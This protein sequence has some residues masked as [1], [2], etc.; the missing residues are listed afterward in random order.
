[1]PS[2]IREI[3]SDSVINRIQ[4]MRKVLC[5][6]PKGSSFELPPNDDVSLLPKSFLLTFRKLTHATRDWVDAAKPSIFSNLHIRFP[7]DKYPSERLSALSHVAP[8]CQHLEISFLDLFRAMYTINTGQSLP[9]FPSLVDLHLDCP[10]PLTI[11]P[12]LSFRQAFQSPSVP[13]LTRLTISNLT[14]DGIKA[15]RFGAFTSFDKAD[16]TS[17]QM[18]QRLKCLDITVV[19]W[20]GKAARNKQNYL[21]PEDPQDDTERW[22]TGLK[23]LHNWLE[24]FAYT[25]S[26]E[27]LNFRW[28]G[29]E[30]PNPLLLDLV[31]RETTRVQWFSAKGTRWRGLKQIQLMGVRVTE[32]DVKLIQD[33]VA[34]LRSWR[35]D[36]E[37]VGHDV[38]EALPAQE[39]TIGNRN[40]ILIRL[41]GLPPRPAGETKSVLEELEL[42]V[43]NLLVAPELLENRVSAIDF[44][45]MDVPFELRISAAEKW[46]RDAL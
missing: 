31:A 12:L 20:F 34:D 7:L 10:S 13:L 35:A 5:R 17:R 46:Y 29:Q 4:P 36:P 26:L 42:V 16:P 41:E 9:T 43:D 1:M 22:R 45:S 24:S 2:E 33:R 40:S 11:Q 18:W 39:K 30:G 27:T 25:G 44:A 3:R 37:L 19:P 32:D 6:H 8:H 15:L 21:K 38:P 14:L 28:Q 23:L